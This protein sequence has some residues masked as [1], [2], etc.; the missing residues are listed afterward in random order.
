M[1]TN[2]LADQR[3]IE[4]VKNVWK[5]MVIGALTGA[6]TGVALDI[7]KSGVEGVA[8]LSGAV[9]EHAPEVAGRVRQAVGDVATN[10]SDFGVVSEG[11][12]SK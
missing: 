9:V 3:E 1:D 6:A 4:P 12:D 10:T 8:A 11:F 7:G 5:G 2:D